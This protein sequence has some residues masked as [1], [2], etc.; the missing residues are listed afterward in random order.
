MVSKKSILNNELLKEVI[1]IRI[2]TLWKMLALDEQGKL[3]EVEEEGATGKY[4]NK[5]AIFVPG[6]LI[7]QDVDEEYI[8]YTSCDFDE[9]K[10]FRKQIRN[11]MLYDNATLLF[12][13]GIVPGVNIDS[14]FFSRAARRINTYKKAAFK[15]KKKIGRSKTFEIDSSDII[16]SHCP[17]Y[18]SP[19]YGSR[20]RVSAYIA[21]GL[22]EPAMFFSYCMAELNFCEDQIEIFSEKFDRVR[23]PVSTQDGVVLYTPQIVVCHDSRYSEASFTGLTKILG[24]GKFGEFC[25]F[26]L[27]RAETKLHRELKRKKQEYTQTDIFAEYNGR[28][29]LGILRIYGPTNPG[30]RSQKYKLHIVSPSKDLDLQVEQLEKEAREQYRI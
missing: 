14:G 27:E 4:D 3:P 21:M 26:T 7:H 22:M 29:V 8:E 2:N 24:I 25:T 6:G 12:P 11:A 23:D 20:T 28:R 18:F 30:K 13:D 1:S 15:R 10:E 17:V 16:R 5:G 9:P 19:P